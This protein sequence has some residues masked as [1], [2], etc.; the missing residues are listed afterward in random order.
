MS[1]TILSLQGMSKAFYGVHALQ[2]VSLEIQRGRVLG[3]VGQNGA[4]KSTLMN[5]VGGVVAPDTGTMVLED[6][7]YRAR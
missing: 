1:D 6:D 3:L 7:A 4:G 5:I 2:D